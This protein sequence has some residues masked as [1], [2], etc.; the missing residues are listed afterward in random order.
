MDPNCNLTDQLAFARSILEQVDKDQDS[1]VTR[2]IVAGFAVRLAENVLALNE[3]ITKGGFLPKP[4]E[5]D[6]ST[7]INRFSAHPGTCCCTGAP[8]K[9]GMGCS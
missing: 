6:A 1:E 4:W 9:L 8:H 5:G 3:W 7:A 2:R